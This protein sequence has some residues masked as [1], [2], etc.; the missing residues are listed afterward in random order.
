MQVVITGAAGRLGQILQAVWADGKPNGFRPVWSVRHA[1]GPEFLKWDILSDPAPALPKGCV[2]LHFA[3]R[4][5]GDVAALADNAKMALLV[6]EAAKAAGAKHVFFASSSAVYG[7]GAA[8]LSEVHAPDPRSEYGRAKLDMERDVLCWA[9]SAGSGAPGVTCLR[10][11]NVLGADALFGQAR[12][13]HEIVL[14]AVPGQKGGPLRSYIGPAE[15]AQ[16]LAGLVGRVKANADMPKILNVAT[17][18]AVFMADL[19]AAGDLCFRFG[20]PN[21]A[22]IP[23]V[24]LATARLAALVPLAAMQAAEMVQEWQQL[25]ARLP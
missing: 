24:S 22:V 20:P 2:I 12:L 8:D 21:H 1:A 9:Q 6:C 3:G 4:L 23:K 17:P 15:F 11:G 7:P 10:I 25:V 16:T 14:D 18:G 19:L 13:G 5:R